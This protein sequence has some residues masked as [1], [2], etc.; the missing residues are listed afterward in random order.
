[1]L[2]HCHVFSQASRVCCFQWQGRHSTRCK[3]TNHKDDFETI[4]F[5]VEKFER[6]LNKQFKLLKIGSEWISHKILF[7]LL[8]QNVSSTLDLSMHINIIGLL[9]D[10]FHGCR[11][12]LFLRNVQTS[13][14]SMPR[15]L[16]SPNTESY[17]WRKPFRFISAPFFIQGA[18]AWSWNR[19]LST[20]LLLLIMCQCGKK[21]FKHLPVMHEEGNQTLI[22]YNQEGGVSECKVC[23]SLPGAW[24]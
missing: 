2:V 16:P 20:V 3:S 5:E 4:I 19:C 24:H 15:K 11:G 13:H 22:K 12:C 8:Q 9:A 7:C 14:P 21:D 6:S 18:F 23:W 1:M 10:M 17:Y